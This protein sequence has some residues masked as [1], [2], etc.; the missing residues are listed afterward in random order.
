[1]EDCPFQV[2]LQEPHTPFDM[3]DFTLD[4]VKAVVR[5]AQAGSTPGPSGTTYKIY[6][7]CPHLLKRLA[8]LLRTLWRKKPEP[9]LWTLAEGSFVP[10]E[11]NSCG[12]DQSR[13][14]SLLDVEG[15]IFWSIIAKR[16]TSYLPTVTLTLRC[17]Q[18]SERGQ[19]L[20]R[21]EAGATDGAVQ[22]QRTVSGTTEYHGLQSNY[23]S[24]EHRLFFG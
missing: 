15:K 7:N 23:H 2:P 8:K 17:P 9:W 4:E 20:L 3:S 18:G 11:L 21:K 6:K 13:E 1:M 24:G 16:L 22:P 19:S 10:K 14:I 12:L 5:K